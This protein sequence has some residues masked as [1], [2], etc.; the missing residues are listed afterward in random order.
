MFGA[1]WRGE[2]SEAD[3]KPGLS[4]CCLN[5]APVLKGE[6]SWDPKVFPDASGWESNK[7]GIQSPRLQMPLSI[8]IVQPEA[9]LQVSPVPEIV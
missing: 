2:F 8:P 1:E 5:S 3:A 7:K 4:H 9:S 6:S